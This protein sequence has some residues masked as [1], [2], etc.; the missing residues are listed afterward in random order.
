[1][2]FR[3]ERQ[4]SK[5]DTAVF[6]FYSVES[7]AGISGVVKPVGGLYTPLLTEVDGEIRYR[8]NSPASVDDYNYVIK[9]IISR[10]TKTEMWHA[11]YNPAAAGCGDAKKLITDALDKAKMT[12]EVTDKLDEAKLDF[13]KV[14]FEILNF[15]LLFGKKNPLVG[16]F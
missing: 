11:Y 16:K 3:W 2:R 4:K 7:Q 13:G 9:G 15:P 1:M 5:D 6:I 10:K 12:K 14:G 8:N